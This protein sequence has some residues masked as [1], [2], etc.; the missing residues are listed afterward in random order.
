MR[1]K[2][3]PVFHGGLVSFRALSWDSAWWKKQS[4]WLCGG[5]V[6]EPWK[7]LGR[8][9]T[10]QTPSHPPTGHWNSCTCCP[11]Q[12]LHRLTHAPSTKHCANLITLLRF[13]NMHTHLFWKQNIF[14]SLKITKMRAVSH[15]TILCPLLQKQTNKQN[16]CV[17]IKRQPFE[18][19]RDAFK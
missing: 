9:P 2:A 4:Q 18:P 17:E 6:K 8:I 11:S 19:D 3:G 7:F 14:S 1:C 12:T 16:E 15:F 10:L 13:P 5:Q